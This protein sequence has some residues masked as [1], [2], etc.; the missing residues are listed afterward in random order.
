MYFCQVLDF[1]FI[2]KLKANAMIRI[3]SYGLRSRTTLATVIRNRLQEVRDVK[4]S[5]IKTVERR[6]KEA[7]KFR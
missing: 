5:C 4:V 2:N 7:I 6:V 1:D 3:V